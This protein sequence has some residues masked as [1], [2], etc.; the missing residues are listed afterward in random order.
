MQ[1]LKIIRSKL[2]YSIS[3]EKLVPSDHPVRQLEHAMDL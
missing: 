3:L 1:G 2:F